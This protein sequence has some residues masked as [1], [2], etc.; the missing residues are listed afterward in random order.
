MLPPPCPSASA[1]SVRAIAAAAIRSRLKVPIRLMSM[2]R[3]KAARS[4]GVPS[5]ATVRAA[6]PMPAQLT[7]TRSGAPSPAAASTA[8]CT[9]CSSAT[10]VP[11]NSPPS[12]LAVALPR[13]SFRSAT[14]TRA[15]AAASSRAVAAPQ[16]AHGYGAGLTAGDRPEQAADQQQPPAAQQPNAERARPAV[17]VDAMGGDNAPDEIV[18]G[19]VAAAR[20]HG[21]NVVLAGRPGQLR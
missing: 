10:S 8:A 14:T 4:C 9:D 16:G 3:R 15:P 19:A 12:S 2:T 17:A 11:T 7:A 1:G 18:A 21:I 13:S 20:Q 6:Q 5:R